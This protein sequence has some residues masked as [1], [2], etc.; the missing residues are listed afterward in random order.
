[1]RSHSSLPNASASGDSSFLQ[2]HLDTCVRI[3]AAAWYVTVTFNPNMQT[4]SYI[5][6]KGSHILT[7]R[8][9]SDPLFACAT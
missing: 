1:M 3:L 4:L 2:A 5:I 7:N 6:C 8:D 9:E